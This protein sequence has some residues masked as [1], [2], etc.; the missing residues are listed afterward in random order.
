MISVL[1]WFANYGTT[2]HQCRTFCRDAGQTATVQAFAAALTTQ[3]NTF[4]S[5][6]A[7]LQS[8]YANLKCQTTSLIALQNL[9]HHDLELFHGIKSMMT[10]SITS[11]HLL[12]QLHGL[13]CQSHAIG[14]HSLHEFL[15]TLFL[16]PLETYLRP[17]HGWMTQGILNPSNHPEFFIT[18]TLQNDHP[19]YHLIRENGDPIAPR[20]MLHI[21]NRVLAAGKTMDF[22]KHL[23]PLSP[24][25]NDSFASFLE[26]EADLGPDSMNPFEHAFET[27]LDAWIMTKYDFASEALRRMLHSQKDLWE[28][29]DRLHGVYC[30][31]SYREMT[32]FTENLFHKVWLL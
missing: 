10:T 17:L 15:L 30:M 25:D 7:D 24:I 29:L 4:K 22:I 2:I 5:K 26:D 8:V 28:Q 1:A 9:L 12:T 11:N 20:F 32:L 13:V 27:A 16:P 21:V 18:F 3:L 23:S 19:V 31:L 6:L 14:S